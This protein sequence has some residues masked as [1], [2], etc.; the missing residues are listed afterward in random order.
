MKLLVLQIPKSLWKRQ[1]HVIADVQ[2][3]QGLL[4]CTEDKPSLEQ[5][6]SVDMGDD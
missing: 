2:S 4:S 6:L 5:K 3:K 1:L